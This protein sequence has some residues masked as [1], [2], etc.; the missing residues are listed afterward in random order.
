MKVAVLDMGTN[1]FNLVIASVSKDECS[2]IKILKI[3]S[4]I[5]EGGMTKGILLPAAF[6][7]T[8][9]AFKEIFV[10]IEEAGGVDLIKAFATSA[11]R[12]ASNAGEYIS[13]I[14]NEFGTDVEII[15]GDRE[16]E[17]V[18]KGVRESI[19]LYDE[20]VLI[21]DVGGGSNELIIADKEK[22]FWKESFNL[23]VVRL[24][25]LFPPSDPIK[26]SEV[27]ALTD[28]LDEKMDTLWAACKLY[29]PT[30]II[31]CSGSFDTIRELIYTEDD[32]TLPAHELEM[33][34][35]VELHERL[36]K[37]VR[38][39]RAAMKGMSPI[40]VDYIV[41][42]SV[43]INYIISRTGIKELYQSS[44]S[45]KEGSIAEIAASLHE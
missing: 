44:Y 20:K 9:K 23:G 25:E 4:K 40:R 33:K 43:L 45:L 5:G 30:L 41:T 34:K 21:I 13:M 16:A 11:V 39:E 17:L 7:S 1:V 42:G 19:L 8:K 36:L 18:Y 12:G 22:I 24:R 10:A 27:D 32:G 37:S 29:K 26:Q 3:P 38:D 15:T 28:Y 2:V 35:L 6:E 31:G 14:K